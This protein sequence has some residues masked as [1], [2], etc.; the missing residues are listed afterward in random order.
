MKMY[1]VTLI[2]VVV[3]V[4]LSGCTYGKRLAKL[5]TYQTSDQDNTRK[6]AKVLNEHTQ[7]LNIINQRAMYIDR[8]SAILSCYVKSPNPSP[9][10]LNRCI[11]EVDERAKK[12]AQEKNVPGLDDKSKIPGDPGDT[13][14]EPKPE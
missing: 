8:N 9:K 1:Q 10:V 14:T 11:K 3:I 6:I 12:K 7:A 5:E 4:L 2:L 13:P